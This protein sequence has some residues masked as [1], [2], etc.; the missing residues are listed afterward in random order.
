MTSNDMSNKEYRSGSRQSADRNGSASRNGSSVSKPAGAFETNASYS[1]AEVVPL[2]DDECVVKVKRAAGYKNYRAARFHV[3]VGQ[4]YHEG[5]K[6]AATMEWATQHF[7]KIIICVNDTLQR[8]NL[9]FEG[10]TPEE[11][12]EEG[13]RLGSEWVER[14]TPYISAAMQNVDN[15]SSLRWETWHK[16]PEFEGELE[17]VNQLYNR[18]PFIKEEIDKEAEAFWKRRQASNGHTDSFKKAQFI[19][20]SIEYLKEECAI[21]RIM[22]REEPPAADVY[23]GSSLLPCRLFKEDDSDSTHGFTKIEFRAAQNENIIIKGLDDD[24]DV[25]HAL[26]KKTEARTYYGRSQSVV[27]KCIKK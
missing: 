22:F 26:Q 23:P 25:S 17:H 2:N 5:S 14:N 11:A 6:F 13:Y 24:E 4:S 15:V 1:Q 12:F 8:H 21:F 7:D 19:A 16:H 9:I 20:H 3:S 18:D 10:K 27:P